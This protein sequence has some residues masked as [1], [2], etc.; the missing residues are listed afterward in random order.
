MRYR[1][2]S[3]LTCSLSKEEIM[4]MECDLLVSN[5]N[6]LQT[7]ERSMKENI[8]RISEGSSSHCGGALK[9]AF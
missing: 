3:R 7:I 9:L 5:F 4:E 2:W 8:R 1:Q 6:D